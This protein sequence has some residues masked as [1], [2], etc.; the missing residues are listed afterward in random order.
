MKAAILHGPRDFR[1]ENVSDPK[2]QPDGIIVR[3]KACGICGSELPLY[4]RGLPSEA[5]Q[6]RGLEAVSMSMLGHEWSGEVAEVGAN[7]THIKPGGRVIGSGYG[8]FAEYVSVSAR[9]V[10]P[11]PD[12][13]SYE[14][15]A[16]VEP[17]GIGMNV[18]MNAEPVA[19]DTVVVFGAGTIGQC[20]W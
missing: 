5:V 13:M 17:T 12:P 9:S 10:M 15:G 1:V 7:V 20:T 2:L 16:T 11:L 8:A 18:A 6:K 19:E 14:V 3:V 4:K